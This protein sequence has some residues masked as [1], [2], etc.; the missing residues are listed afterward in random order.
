MYHPIKILFLWC[1]TGVCIV[2]QNTNSVAITGAASCHGQGALDRLLKA[3][4]AGNIRAI[5]RNATAP[6]AKPLSDKGLQASYSHIPMAPFW[7]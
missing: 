6:G 1:C 5:V 7:E 2:A 4:P 3:V